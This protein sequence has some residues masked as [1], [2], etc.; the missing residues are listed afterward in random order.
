MGS[1]PRWRDR[2][3]GKRSKGRK[4]KVTSCRVKGQGEGATWEKGQRNGVVCVSKGGMELEAKV[5]RR[6]E[7]KENAEWIIDR[8]V[9]VVVVVTKMG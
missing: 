6:R 5:E 9:V 1:G 8:V 3:C 7:G 4:G 2:Q